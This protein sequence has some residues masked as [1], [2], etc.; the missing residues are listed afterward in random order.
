MSFDRNNV[1]VFAYKKI[2]VEIFETV[3]SPKK[4][5]VQVR[6]SLWAPKKKSLPVNI[7]TSDCLAA[8]AE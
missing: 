7:N 8:Y 1:S 6:K 3:I 4:F 2:V 5:E